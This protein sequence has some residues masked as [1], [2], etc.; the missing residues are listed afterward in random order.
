[1]SDVRT[2]LR[3]LAGELGVS[4]DGLTVEQ[5]PIVADRFVADG[6]VK[7]D[8][9]RAIVKDVRE[10]G[11]ATAAVDG[12]ALTRPTPPP[13]PRSSA[14]KAVSGYRFNA[15]EADRKQREKLRRQHATENARTGLYLVPTPRETL[16]ADK[17][18]PAC[19]A[20]ARD[21][22]TPCER[23]SWLLDDDP[24]TEAWVDRDD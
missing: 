12:A 19:L 7:A 2:P 23:C 20:A 22:G 1:M 8:V 16:P 24:Y 5:L 9:L 14:A 10:G 6:R 13:V 15:T 21:G 11:G 17:P 3:L 4:L 18:H